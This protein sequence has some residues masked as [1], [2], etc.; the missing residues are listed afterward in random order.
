MTKPDLKTTGIIEIIAM[1][2]YDPEVQMHRLKQLA[3]L[4]KK[5]DD[6][7]ETQYNANKRYINRF[8]TTLEKLV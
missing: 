4:N 7:D 8:I 2:Q 5:R 3:S 1:P 6:I